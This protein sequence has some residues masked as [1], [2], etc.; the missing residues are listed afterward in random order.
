MSNNVVIVGGGIAGLAASIVLARGGRSVTLFEKRRYLGGR[1]VTHLRHGYRFNL[2]P[3]AFY[4]G[5]EGSRVL[6]ELGIPVRGGV[7]KQRGIA[8]YHDQ[9]YRLPA[10]VFSLWFTGLLSGADKF[11]ASK[12]LWRIRRMKN[13][14]PFAS[15]SV[16]QWLDA[17]VTR[18]RV[19]ETFEALLRLATYCPDM[20]MMSAAAALKQLRLAMRGV[21]YVDEGWQKIVDALHSSAVAA[22]V[23][24]VTSSQVIRVNHDEAVNGIEIGG[25]EGDHDDDTESY[26]RARPGPAHGTRVPADTVLLAVDPVTACNLAGQIE[27]PKMTPVLLSTL[28]VALSRLPQPS[29]TFAIGIDRPLYYSVH[30]RA[31]QL[32]PKGGALLHV[33]RYGGGDQAELET[34][35][36]EM[37]PGWRDIVVHCRFLP[38]MIV[39]NA[40]VPPAP[41]ARPATRTPVRGLFVA[42]DW[43]GESG[44]LS[45]A[46]LASARDAARAMLQ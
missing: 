35:L 22:G 36:D 39:S 23:N 5:G 41:A 27:W 3:H 12:L 7:P 26:V 21:I 45:D 40:I 10:G 34:L 42:G 11:E 16:R 17:N 25:L 20:Q 28:D 44:L 15:M 46:A 4:R 18:A 24:F 30:S 31:A 43:V 37:Q 9:R 29:K 33:A 13:P 19:R 2:G 32:T 14:A 38:S 6:A 8:L 1:A